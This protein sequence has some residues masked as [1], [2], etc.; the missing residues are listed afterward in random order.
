VSFGSAVILTK[1]LKNSELY[2][3]TGLGHRKIL[4]DKKTI[5]RLVDFLIKN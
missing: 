3:T 2:K 5:N 4:G 1:E